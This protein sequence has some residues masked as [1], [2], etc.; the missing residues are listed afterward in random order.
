MDID[1]YIATHRPDWQRLEDLT[2]RAERSVGRLTHGELD[3][4]VDLLQR[5]SSHLSTV[6]TTYDDPAL[7]SHLS[8]L[9][10]RAGAIVHGTRGRSWA[11]LVRS[12]TWTFPAA[13]WHVRRPI[14]ASAGLFLVAA[15]AVGLWI[16]GSSAA[17]EASMPAEVR[18]AY[19]QRD[20]E[21]YYSSQ[22]AAQFASYVFTNNVRVA[23]LA[24]GGGILLC[25]PTAWVI[26]VNGA[27]LGVAAGLFTA[28]GLA[29]RFWGLILPHGLLE[30]T[31]VFIAG[32]AGLRLGWTV[33]DPGDRTRARALADEGRRTVVIILGLVAVFLVAGL[34]E[35]FVT[36][37]GLPTW[38]RVGIGV[39]TEAAFLAFIV[40]QGR[41]AAARGITGALGEPRFLAVTDAREP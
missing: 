34:I 35:A 25:V 2:G 5:V 20:F 27:H 15:L 6:R 13:V 9:V 14:L 18:E 37:S 39:L 8:R 21:A 38:G 24:F 11:D 29:G 23:I 1:R 17:Y 7:S 28:S 3:E 10:A 31:A 36:P 40:V 32:G 30:L 16:T 26:A 33:I 41:L 4:L 19:L 12:W 22:P